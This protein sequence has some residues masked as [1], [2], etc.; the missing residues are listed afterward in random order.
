M[1]NYHLPVLLKESVDALSI[2]ECSTIIDV[3]FG[4]GGHSREILNRLDNDGR[5]FAFDQDHEAQDNI[6]ND[7]RFTLIDKNFKYLKNFLRLYG[8][9]KADG[10]L[11]DLGVSSHQF[12]QA[13]RGFSTR[14]DAELDMRMDI[15]QNLTAKDIINQYE[16]AE[17]ENI[18]RFYGELP[19]ARRLAHEICL[20]RQTNSI[21][22]TFELKEAVS[23]LMPKKQENK[24]FAM[25]FQALR[26]EV[27]GEL[28][29]LKQMLLQAK[30][31]LKDGGRLV[32]ISY[33]SLEDR[34]VKNFMKSGNFEGKIEKD[35][36]GNILT[37]FNVISRKIIVPSEEEL[38][39]N[40]RSRSAKLRI[41]EKK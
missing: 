38:N 14:F 34:L 35:F 31:I 29:A 21:Q 28:D 30:D 3:T 19:N 23:H 9:E 39:V 36:Y 7:P 16:E 24:F 4:G 15:R 22:T 33:H 40:N 11:A 32:V 25:L 26:I 10:I 17:L 6:I 5:L 41:A 20:K 27:N 1:S 2:G 37:P 8:V 18:F 13:E 12:D